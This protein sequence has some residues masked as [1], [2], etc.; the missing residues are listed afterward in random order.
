MEKNSLREILATNCAFV[1][2][3]AGG[4][5]FEI[6]H[7]DFVSVSPDPGTAVIVHK[8]DGLGFSVLDLS[9]ISDIQLHHV[10][11]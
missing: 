11:A 5:R 6:G 1:I 4:E 10:G 3:T 2:V 7:P 8:E 9:T